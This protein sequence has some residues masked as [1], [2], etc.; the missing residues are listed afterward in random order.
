MLHLS[1]TL[2]MSLQSVLAHK[3]RS[4][5]TILGV[6]FGVA[7]VV[8]M[9]SIGEGAKEE[10]LEQ[11]SVM[12]LHN[13]IVR[14]VSEEVQAEKAKDQE[15]ITNSQGLTTKD[16]DAIAAECSF[17]ETVE[18][19]GEHR[20]Q[21]FYGGA[22]LDVT[23]LGV[24]PAYSTIYNTVLK[25]GRSITDRDVADIANLCVLGSEAKQ[26]LFAYKKALGEHVKLGDQWFT[27]VGIAQEKANIAKFAGPDARNINLDIYVPVTTAELKFGRE[28]DH[29]RN[30]SS[31]F[32]IN[33]FAWSSGGNNEKA[34]PPIDQITV[35]L[36]ANADAGEAAS[37]ISRI[38]SRRHNNAQDFTVTVP[39]ELLRQSQATQRIFN[40]V[41][42]AIASISLLV[43]GIGI[44]NIMLASVLERTHEIGIRRALG[45]TQRVVI[46]QFLAEAII[47]SMSGG[48]TGVVLGYVMTRMI[49]TYAEWRTII[50]P[51]SV[52]VA[53]GVS[54][55]TGILFGY[56]PARQAARKDPIDALRYE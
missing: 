1:E 28:K 22:H 11:I 40:I 43:G 49:S 39:E 24:T 7:A 53:F 30:N 27:V 45:A 34:A 33:G 54:V 3:V 6:V 5:L 32:V 19:N 52:I 25:E 16:A 2:N 56:Y 20:E 47:L 21:A 23:V 41:M 37:I 44:M 51:L 55:A 15:T 38:L 31:S 50:T 9:L 36:K 10:T 18:A 17:A 29:A 4:V 46:S 48:V 26:K 35:K 12:G 13:I 42:L 8:A 14:A